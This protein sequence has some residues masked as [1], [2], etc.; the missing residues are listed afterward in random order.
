[1]TAAALLPPPPEAPPP[2]ARTCAT[3][4]TPL[5]GAFCSQC[6]EKVLDRHDYALGHVLEHG[7]DAFT[8]F[9]VKV[10]KSLWSLFRRPGL[11]AADVLAGRRVA[12]AKPFQLFIVA[13]ILYYLIASALE[14][15][16]FQ[17]PLRYHLTGWYGPFV[18]AVVTNKAAYLGLSPEA[19]A[20]RFDHQAH[21]L[22]KSLLILLVPFVA[23]VLKGLFFARRRYYLEH[24]TAALVLVPALVLVTPLLLP[25]VIALMA[26]VGSVRGS[27]DA[28]W[29]LLTTVV[30][31]LY[32]A[33]FFRRV[34]GG[35]RWVRVAKAFAFVFAW[36]TILIYVYRPI[37]F[38]AAQVFTT[39]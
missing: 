7:V 13:N 4:G 14:I 17:T 36:Y 30:Y 16:T 25:V 37:L 39:R 22:S 38:L 2:S 27:G 1:M 24:F 21:G 5:H 26:L 15:N 10:L 31:T 8:H 34:Y 3:C 29:T 12:W 35:R 33:V 11:M 23:L 32:L 20:E 9:D 18:E 28:W 6:G 19:Y